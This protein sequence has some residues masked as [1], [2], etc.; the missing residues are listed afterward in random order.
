MPKWDDEG[1]TAEEFQN[2]KRELAELVRAIINN[3]DLQPELLSSPYST[4][5]QSFEKQLIMMF[6]E[7]YGGHQ[8]INRLYF[9]DLGRKIPGLL[10]TKVFE[11]FETSE[12]VFQDRFR[13]EVRNIE[14][15]IEFFAVSI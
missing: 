2:K 4:N 14:D 3:P 13:V 12:E 8:D 5:G 7:Q 10:L 6:E 11:D 9:C 15:C 1:L